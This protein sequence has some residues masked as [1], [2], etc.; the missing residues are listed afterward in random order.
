[1]E[2]AQVIKLRNLYKDTG[3]IV[4]CDN[5]KIFTN[6]AESN[7]SLELN[8]FLSPYLSLHLFSKCPV[9]KL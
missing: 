3:Y 7:D 5:M 4:T 1:M 8:F 9:I 2:K 6:K